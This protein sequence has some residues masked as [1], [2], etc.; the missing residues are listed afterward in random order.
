LGR[1]TEL[2]E[3]VNFRQ[4]K[5]V[6][7][8]ELLENGPRKDRFYVTLSH[9]WG[10]A[11]FMTLTEDKFARFHGGIQIDTLPRTFRDAISFARRLSRQVRYIWIDSLCIIQGNSPAQYEDWLRE[12]SQMFQ[13]Y[14]NS[15][16]NLSAT[17][18]ADSEKDLFFK[19]EPRELWEDDINLNVEGI[20][21]K[22]QPWRQELNV[23]VGDS[24]ILQICADE[25][26]SRS[27][28][29]IHGETTEQRIER[30]RIL[31]VSFWERHVDDTPVNR[32]GWVLQERLMA[33]RVLHFCQ[34]Q[35]AWEC[36]D[37]EAAES[38]RT[39]L[40]I[41]RIKAGGDV[42]PGG[43]LKSLIPHREGDER[44]GTQTENPFHDP[45][46]PTSDIH[47]YRC[48]KH[49]VEVYSKTRLTNP[50]DKLI[51]LSGI[52]KMMH[53][54]INDTYLAG[55]WSKYL[56]SQLLW[57]VDPVYEDG[58]FYYRSER[59]KFFRAPT[60]S[61]AA[62]DA[63]HGVK[64]GEITDEGLLIEVEEVNVTPVSEENKFGLVDTGYLRLRG[65][66]KRIELEENRKNDAVRFSWH[67]M[68]NMDE[69]VITHWNV[70]LD[71]PESDTDILG[72]HG[73]PTVCQ[74]GRMM[75]AI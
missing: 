35:I 62:V 45:P 31:D 75:L 64:C 15:Y 30:C 57:Y 74:L 66:M 70:Y 39:G 33:P 61:W 5:L 67:L 68:T 37:L 28:G 54:Q 59:P 10:K 50:E 3:R 49:V 16:C 69:E 53:D 44:N 42:I 20:P 52:A 6:L 60:F 58:R 21:G 63:H 65:V 18:A 9:C 36:R 25:I 55:M 51:S 24:E 41:F 22:G 29:A 23:N 1:A 14:R 11:K 32:R 48:C 26:L 8:K 13:I 43:K 56:A 46:H 19:R 2:N 38:A 7:T 40:P 12:S 4:V 34:D 71:S 72:R 17:A 47:F 27:V 73:R